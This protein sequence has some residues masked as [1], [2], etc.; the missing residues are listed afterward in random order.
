M[1]PFKGM[2]L[3]EQDIDTLTGWLTQ[4]SKLISRIEG[5]QAVDGYQV[6]DTVYSI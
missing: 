6:L 5:N 3:E 4:G 2:Y 1:Q